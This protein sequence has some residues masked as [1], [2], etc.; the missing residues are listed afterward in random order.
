MDAAQVKQTVHTV[1]TNAQKTAQ[2]IQGR[3]TDNVRNVRETKQRADLDALKQ[4]TLNSLARHAQSVG[5]AIEGQKEKID[6]IRYPESTLRPLDSEQARQHRVR[7]KYDSLELA[8]SL[9]QFS[10]KVAAMLLQ[11]GQ[12]DALSTYVDLM[13][14]GAVG[15]IETDATKSA[16]LRSVRIVAEKT[17]GLSDALKEMDALRKVG[18]FVEQARELATQGLWNV[19]GVQQVDAWARAVEVGREVSTG[20]RELTVGALA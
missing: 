6:A 16:Q 7:L 13:S 4:E 8:L 11:R 15:D 17:P 14:S 19:T 3:Y 9:P 1:W 12:I 20:R 18:G 2:D 5:R 10:D